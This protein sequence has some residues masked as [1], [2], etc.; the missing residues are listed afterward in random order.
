MESDNGLAAWLNNI[1]SQKHERTETLLDL[2]DLL[3]EI[4]SL[5]MG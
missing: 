5:T 1:V 3:F 4:V 2:A